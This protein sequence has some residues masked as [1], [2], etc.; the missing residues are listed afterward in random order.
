[1]ITITCAHCQKQTPRR[2]GDVNRALKLGAPVY[3]DQ[4]CSGLARRTPKLPLAERKAKKAD[5]DA[6]R[7]VQLADEI[8]AEKAERH[9]LTYTYEAAKAKREERKRRLGADY[10]T[11]YCRQYFARDTK[12]KTRKVSY[13]MRRRD[14]RF[15]EF[16]A[17]AKLLRE[18]E[19]VIRKQSLDAYERRKARGYYERCAQERKRDA[20][21]SRW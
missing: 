18:L 2:T 21:V 7:R 12:R 5:Y 17:C 13:D 1:M 19:A 14:A 11:R 9:R 10:H 6:I 8:K 15:G 4:T 3:C 20:S 16:A